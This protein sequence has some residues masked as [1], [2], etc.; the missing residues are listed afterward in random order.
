LKDEIGILKELNHGH[1]IRLYDTFEDMS[2]YYLVTEMMTGGELFDRIVA[3]S[4]YSEKEA[5]DVCKIL[6]SALAYCHSK[7]VAHRD[8]KPEN[9]LL[10][11]QDDD[12]QIKIADFGFAKKVTSDECL[13]TQCGTP[14]YVAPEILEGNPYGTKCDDWSMG[15]IAYI[16]LGGYPPFIEQNQRELFKK[17]RKGSFEFHE[18]YW[19]QISSEAKDMIASLLTVDPKKRLTCVEAIQNSWIM[20]GDDALSQVDLGK[21]LGEFK[22]FNAKRKFRQAVL[23]LIATNK[24]TSLGVAFRSNLSS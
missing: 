15:V 11:S 9:L 5:R 20:G 13:L 2:E 3:K 24:M 6:F 23:T 4:Y 21:N 22:K 1:I 8:L 17:I 19:S 18:E 16:I 14:G 12:L 7:K 10:V